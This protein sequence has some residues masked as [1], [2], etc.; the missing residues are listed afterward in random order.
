MQNGLPE[1]K[2]LDI[3]FAKADFTNLKLF[4]KSGKT[5]FEGGYKVTQDMYTQLLEND[6]NHF[7]EPFN[8]VIPEAIEI[9]E[10][11]VFEAEVFIDKAM[12][13]H[14]LTY[15]NEFWQSFVKHQIDI[16]N[17]KVIFRCHNFEMTREFFSH[18]IVEDGFVEKYKL[19]GAYSDNEENVS[20]YFMRS[21]LWREYSK[22]NDA[23]TKEKD[24]AD[25]EKVMDNTLISVIKEAK[26]FTLS[27]ETVIGF[28][29]G[30]EFELKNLKLILEG[31][32]NNV[33]D[34]VI[35][36]RLRETYV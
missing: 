32:G 31:K 20:K 23:H 17:F 6:N 25:M 30:M 35:K 11:S 14:L 34:V 36:E 27:V 7:P 10:K 26:F 1:E 4:I 12:F 16:T 13:K 18:L 28:I 15:K 8:K 5:D 21:E 3:Y 2:F 24:F 33:S 22:M 19:L 9:K 29:L